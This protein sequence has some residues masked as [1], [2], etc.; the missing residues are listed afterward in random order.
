VARR[1]AL[2]ARRLALAELQEA[3]IPESVELPTAAWLVAALWPMAVRLEA[4]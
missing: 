3:A 1:L 4:A 2:A